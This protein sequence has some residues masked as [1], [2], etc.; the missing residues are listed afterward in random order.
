MIALK[1]L[2]DVV[3]KIEDLNKTNMCF[4][5]KH[6]SPHDIN[7]MLNEL[8]NMHRLLEELQQ[9]YIIKLGISKI[10]R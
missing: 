2:K 5:N 4:E 6:D 8:D 3:V 1:D 7:L 10:N 9:K